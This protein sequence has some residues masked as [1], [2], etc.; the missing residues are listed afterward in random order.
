VTTATI[1][2]NNVEIVV[3]I[4]AISTIESWCEE[5]IG[6]FGHGWEWIMVSRNFFV[7][8]IHDKEHAVLFRLT[9][10]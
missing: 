6:P 9:F 3:S 10:R 5:H 8:N 7:L 2:H 1:L 4:D